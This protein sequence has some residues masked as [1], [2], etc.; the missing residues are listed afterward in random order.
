MHPLLLPLSLALF[1]AASR[2]PSSI[3]SKRLPNLWRLASRNNKML[4]NLRPRHGSILVP[5]PRPRTYQRENNNKNWCNVQKSG[6]KGREMKEWRKKALNEDFSSSCAKTKTTFPPRGSPSLHAHSKTFCHPGL[7]LW[8][9]VLGITMSSCSTRSFK[10][11]ML[12]WYVVYELRTSLHSLE[13][14]EK[15]LFRKSFPCKCFVKRS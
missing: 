5:P 6:M 10:E 12:D 1:P 7:L 13:P 4:S 11:K 2:R 8:S 3:F 14:W 9:L 15:A